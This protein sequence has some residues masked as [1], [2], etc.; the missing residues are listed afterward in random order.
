MQCLVQLKI[1]FSNYIYLRYLIDMQYI[2]CINYIFKYMYIYLSK[3][4][5]ENSR[6]IFHDMT[7]KKFQEL[8]IEN[9][10]GNLRSWYRVS[11]SLCTVCDT[12]KLV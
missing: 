2:S 3:C 6:E 12:R 5:H 8:M 1:L 4:V 10:L 7:P 11:F 9:N